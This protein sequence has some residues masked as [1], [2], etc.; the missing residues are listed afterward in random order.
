MRRNL[1]F[2]AI[3]VLGAIILGCNSAER[4]VSEFAQAADK[5]ASPQQPTPPSDDARRITLPETQELVKKGQAVIIDVR[6]Q[7]S[8]DQG[9]IPGAKLIPSTEILNHLDQL[10]RDKTIVTYCS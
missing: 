9:H 3:I 6:N 8:Y 2:P 4:K 10:P 7:A 5:K 1:L